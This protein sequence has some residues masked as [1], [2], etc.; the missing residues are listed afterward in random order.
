G[1]GTMAGR[2]ARRVVTAVAAAVV[3][4]LV[5]VAVLSGAAG[6]AG[7]AALHGTGLW[8]DGGASTVPPTLFSPSPTPTPTRP[9]P[10]GD[11]GPVLGAVSPGDPVDAEALD[12]RIADVP[13]EDVGKVGAVVLDGETGKQ[14]HASRATTPM[15]PASTM[16][17]LT[18]VAALDAFGPGHRFTTSVVAPEP[19]A[20]VLVGGGD[21]YLRTRAEPAHPERASLDVLAA[22]TAARL[23]AAGT[24]S[25]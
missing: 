5:A 8:I 19:G 12:R 22:R 9:P 7:R 14:V 20:L 15:T 24:T 16:K 2:R 21:P 4:V 25:V 17:L 11:P 23:A 3:A 13:R 6:R 1:R 10:G 18:S